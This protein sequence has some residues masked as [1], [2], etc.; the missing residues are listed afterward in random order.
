LDF[1]ILAK[2]DKSREHEAE[3]IT[4]CLC[5]DVREFRVLM[6]FG[7]CDEPDVEIVGEAADGAEAIDVV[8]ALR[9]D[10]VLLDLSMPGMDGFEVL[11]SLRRV[12]PESRVIVLSGFAASRMEAAAIGR[13]A[14]RYLEKGASLAEIREAV[15]AVGRS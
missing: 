7:L 12:A 4:V 2:A 10:V 8:R 1:P 13:G 5:D 14:A 6:R 11:E 15:R 3:S 9:P